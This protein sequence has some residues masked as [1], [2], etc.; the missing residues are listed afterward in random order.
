[1]WLLPLGDRRVLLR[2]SEVYTPYAARGCVLKGILVRLIRAGWNGWGC[3]RVLVASKAPLPIESLVAEVTRES[4]PRFALSVGAPGR[5][6]KMTVQAMRGDGEILGYLK[7]PLTT[8]AVER[9]RHE[10]AILGRLGE[11]AALRSHV[12]RVLR[13]C[14]L[15][16]WPVLFES[17]GTGLPGPI[18]FG[19]PHEAFLRR[20]WSMYGVQRPGDALV[21]EVAGRWQQTEVSLDGELRALGR[22]AIQRAA[23]DLEK[24]E[25]ACALM[26]GDFAPWNTRLDE[27]RLIVFD[28]ESSV[29]GAPCLWDVFHFVVQVEG[30]CVKSRRRYLRCV[31]SV[32][33]RALFLL[34]LCSSVLKCRE[35][36]SKDHFGLE[37]RRQLLNEVLVL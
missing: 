5:F 9:V 26:H 7:V 32:E 14:E 13:V 4:R 34:Y 10:A 2:A 24:V 23:R 1:M 27:G 25:I 29:W 12:P 31:D 21:K 16:Q 3:Q 17:A 37:V 35:E 19:E 15:E 33:K 36:E 6:Q 20:L 28:W 18:E 22:R 8:P 30:L 11:F